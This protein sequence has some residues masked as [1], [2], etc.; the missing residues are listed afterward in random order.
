MG[1]IQSVIDAL[2]D[3]K[4]NE[5]GYVWIA[6]S[7]RNAMVRILMKEAERLKEQPDIV[8]CKDCKHGIRLDDTNYF[9]C[10][11]PFAGIRETHTGDW[12]CA[13]GERK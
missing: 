12:F 1:N 5:M 6:D 3:A 8:R 10:T 2:Q 9:V 7:A 4:V 13:D 11:K